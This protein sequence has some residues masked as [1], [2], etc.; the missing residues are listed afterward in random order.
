MQNAAEVGEKC[1]KAGPETFEKRVP[2]SRAPG[3]A[4]EHPN[5]SQME[6]KG[7]QMELLGS[8]DL[9]AQGGVLG[10]EIP[11]PPE[12]LLGGESVVVTRHLSLL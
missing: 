9:A 7:A 1:A 4:F 5:G 12:G 2:G 8:L 3:H 11:T 10:R 6:P